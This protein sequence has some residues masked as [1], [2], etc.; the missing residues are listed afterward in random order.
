MINS[1]LDYILI[2]LKKF[3]RL[4]S[5]TIGNN[6][7]RPLRL[8]R[9]NS[10]SNIAARLGNR[11]NSIVGGPNN[12]NI[13]NGN[14]PAP[15]RRLNRTNSFSNLQRSSSRS[16]TNMTT[17]LTRSN[18]RSSLRRAN[19]HNNIN[20][21]LTVLQQ[22]QQLLQKQK[23]QLLALTSRNPRR[24]NVK[25]GNPQQQRNRSNSVNPRLGVNRT[26]QVITLG[27]GRFQGRIGV[28]PIVRGRIIRNSAGP[29]NA[30][31]QQLNQLQNRSRSLSRTR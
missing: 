21:Q 26:N 3:Y 8:Q 31:R 1:H 30:N 9:S 11:R 5:D 20:R 2:C 27:G 7:R 29:R 12:N 18:S 19:N 23:E 15:R 22:Q 24:R 14:G 10:T 6:R 28:K 4:R 25:A 13:Q 17:N 16:N